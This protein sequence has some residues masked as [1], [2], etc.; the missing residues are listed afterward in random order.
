M[1]ITT[2]TAVLY[3]STCLF[4]LIPLAGAFVPAI[5]KISS[6][7]SHDF[8]V[9]TF[10]Q[11]QSQT[12][13][14]TVLGEEEAP[15]GIVGSQF[16]G[17]AKQKEEF[18]DPIAEEQA[19]SLVGVVTEVDPEA[20]TTYDRFSDGSFDAGLCVDL[21]KSLQSQ[22]NAALYERAAAPNSDYTY[23]KSSSFKWDTPFQSSSS[24]SPIEELSSALSFYK[25]VDVAIVGGRQTSES[26]VQLEWEI[27]VVW[28]TFWGPRVLL[29]GTSDLRLEKNDGNTMIVQ[30]TDTLLDNKDLLSSI[31]SQVNPRFWDWYHIGMAPSAEQMPRLALQKPLFGNYQVYEIPSRLALV[32][33]MVDPGDR[34]DRNAQFV[35]NHAFSCAIK[36]MGPSRER[37]VTT[38]PVEVQLIPGGEQLK[39]KWMIPLAVEFQTNLK[40]PLPGDD[41]EA[42]KGSSPEC[43]YER[44]PRRKVATVPYGGEPQD[45]DITEIRKTLYEK[46]IKD[47]LKPKLDDAGRPMFFFIHNTIK[48]CYTEEGLGM[49]VYE[50][51]PRATKANE[52]GIELEYS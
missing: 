8:L 10:A 30:Q 38:T 9:V 49:C 21:A 51:R 42:L 1:T 33:T 36:T 48:G 50:W 19:S 7:S 32:P 43:T 14:T 2:M 41:P 23:S 37:Y 35:P 12:K 27:S 18:Y 3:I 39:L 25:N 22:I 4:L 16:F 24:A 34:D 40:L 26:S 15:A 11:K 13:Q 52:V 20:E 31:G 47:G 46:V 28:P 44:Q 5:S 6:S 45:V 29:M 17:G